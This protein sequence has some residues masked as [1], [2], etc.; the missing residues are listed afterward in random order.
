MKNSICFEAT[1]QVHRN[2]TGSHYLGCFMQAKPLLDS[3]DVKELADPQLGDS[4]D[5]VEMKRVMLAASM[6]INHL[7]TMRP[8]MSQVTL[9]YTN[10]L[11]FQSIVAC[12]V[13]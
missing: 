11:S 10:Y 4:Y 12:F 3:N 9:N 8:H 6:C 5:P 2:A 7:S 13:N 1:I